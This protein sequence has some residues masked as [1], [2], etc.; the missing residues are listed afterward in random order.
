MLNVL[1]VDASSDSG[2]ASDDSSSDEYLMRNPFSSDEEKI[3]KC[4]MRQTHFS[5]VAN[6]NRHIRLKR[7]NGTEKKVFYINL[8]D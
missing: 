4:N 7:C 2:G 3:I 6:L 5:K 1:T 8:T